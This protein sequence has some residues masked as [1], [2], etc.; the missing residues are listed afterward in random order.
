MQEE[1]KGRKEKRKRLAYL[2]VV[3]KLP[4]KLKLLA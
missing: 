4:A 1:Q 3:T 2:V